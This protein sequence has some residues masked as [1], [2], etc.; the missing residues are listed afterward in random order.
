MILGPILWAAFAIC[1]LPGAQKVIAC[2]SIWFTG[3]KAAYLIVKNSSWGTTIRKT[4]NNCLKSNICKV[5]DINQ[6]KQI[7][8]MLLDLESRSKI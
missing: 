1:P 5:T 7:K 4:S 6:N 2:N 3:Q 8:S